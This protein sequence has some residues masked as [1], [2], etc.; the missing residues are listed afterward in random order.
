MSHPVQGNGSGMKTDPNICDRTMSGGRGGDSAALASIGPI[1]RT[2]IRGRSR[3]FKTRRGRK[4]I[5][6]V[7]DPDIVKRAYYA[8]AE[9][10]ATL[11]QLSKILPVPMGTLANWM[12]YDKAF[13]SAVRLGMDAFNSNKVEHALLKRALGY[14]YDEVTESDIEVF[15]QNK[16]GM[17]VKVPAHKTVTTHRVLPPD[18]GALVFYLTNRAPGRWRQT[19]RQ[20]TSNTTESFHQHNVTVDWSKVPKEDLEAL[21]TIISRIE[22]NGGHPDPAPTGRRARQSLLA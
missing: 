11:L 6:A 13:H 7:D 20:E 3:Q 21:R 1:K 5:C 9:M 22:P 15:G 8:C 10:G 17:S 16:L 12:R 18:V 2:V 14:V 4:L 19:Y